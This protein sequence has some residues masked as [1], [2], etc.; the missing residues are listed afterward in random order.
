M[1]STSQSR[2]APHYTLLRAAAA[3]LLHCPGRDELATNNG[4]EMRAI[5]GFTHGT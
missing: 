1:S 2:E 5:I 4:A 3:G